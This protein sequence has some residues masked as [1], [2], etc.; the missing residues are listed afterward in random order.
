MLALGNDPA[1]KGLAVK[2]VKGLTDATE[3]VKLGDAWW[4]LGEKKNGLA[5][6]N[7]LQGHAAFWYQQAMPGLTGLAKEKV[8]KRV[9]VAGGTLQDHDKGLPI[10]AT[11][12]AAAKTWK[13]VFR[14]AEPAIWNTSF[15]DSKS[16]YAIPIAKLPENIRYLRLQI[17]KTKVVIIPITKERLLVQSAEGRYGWQG[18]NS[19]EFGGCHLGV[20]DMNVKGEKVGDIAIGINFGGWND[21]LGW[22][23][24]HPMGP[25]DRQ[26]YSWER[27]AIPKTVFEISVKSVELTSIERKQLLVP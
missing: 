9:A 11:G 15:G 7:I 27:A 2:E 4:D 5:K 26:G 20:Y 24:G 25:N 1:V 13:L 17:D 16:E 22:G 3:R 6:K 10:S 14:S 12:T 23:F 18:T 8:Q 21:R 19:N